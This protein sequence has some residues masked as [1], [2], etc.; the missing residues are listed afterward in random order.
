VVAGWGATDPDSVSRPK[1][2]Q[3]V[4]VV[5]VDNNVCMGWHLATGIRWDQEHTSITLA[6]STVVQSVVA[7]E[8]N[9]L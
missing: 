6:Y 3:A 5:T 4:E 8:Y 1:V 9:I 2:L 7:I